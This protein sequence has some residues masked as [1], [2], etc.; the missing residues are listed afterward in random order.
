MR[1][2]VSVLTASA[3]V[4]A[5]ASAQSLREIARQHGGNVSNIMDI[6]CGIASTAELMAQSDLVLRGTITSS[7]SH[8]KSDETSVVTDY[9]VEPVKVFK[10]RQVASVARPG[11]V[12]QII[13][14]RPGGKVMDGSLSLS[15]SV[16]AYPEAESFKR[17]EDVIVFLV[18]DS[19]ARVYHFTG[20]PFGVFRIASRHV[21]PMTHEVATRRGDQPI[22]LAAFLSRVER[23]ASMRPA[24]PRK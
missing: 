24:A 6:D 9:V 12:A 5:S 13:A 22:D 8:L 14:R 10:Q 16:D 21:H 18:Y 7:K 1:F 19:V 23:E 15:T 4:I 2:C 20:G 17:G 11:E 3:L